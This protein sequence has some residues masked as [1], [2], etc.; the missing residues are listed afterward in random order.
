MVVSAYKTRLGPDYRKNNLNVNLNLTRIHN[1]FLSH[2][3]Q[4]KTQILIL[5]LLVYKCEIEHINSR[6]D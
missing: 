1:L 5:F 2:R 3:N 6:N 4:I